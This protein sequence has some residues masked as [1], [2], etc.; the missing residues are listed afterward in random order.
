VPWASTSGKPDS[1]GHLAFLLFQL[2]DVV[3]KI[4]VD[5][6]HAHRV[7]LASVS[8]YFYAMFNGKCWL[9]A[10]SHVKAGA[11]SLQYVI[12]GFVAT[13]LFVTALLGSAMTNPQLL[14]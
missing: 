13:A 14:K 11:N 3:L 10:G 6:I 8:P 12:I 9:E 4:G 2:C 7:V 5:S 1:D